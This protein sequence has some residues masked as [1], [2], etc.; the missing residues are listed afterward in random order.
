[1][2]I[3]DFKVSFVV[4]Y[5]PGIPDGIVARSKKSQLAPRARTCNWL[6]SIHHS[7]VCHIHCNHLFISR[8][9]LLAGGN[10]IDPI[11]LFGPGANYW[12]IPSRHQFWGQL[13]KQKSSKPV[14]PFFSHQWILHIENGVSYVGLLLT[15]HPQAWSFFHTS[16]LQCTTN[17]LP[18]LKM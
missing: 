12:P 15:L 18:V 5:I 3:K 9:T 14:M 13:A 1:M 4:C 10:G 6:M 7:R 8:A 2:N 17:E 16:L 11:L